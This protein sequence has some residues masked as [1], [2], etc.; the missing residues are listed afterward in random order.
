MLAVVVSSGGIEI[1]ED[2]GM[3]RRARVLAELAGWQE[4]LC[5]SPLFCTMDRILDSY[6]IY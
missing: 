6:T 2:R 5:V 1:R 3:G 4:I